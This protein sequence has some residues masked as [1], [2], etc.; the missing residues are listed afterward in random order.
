MNYE[1]F[2]LGPIETN[3]YLLFSPDRQAAIVDPVEI[4]A[5]MAESIGRQRLEVKFILVTH[6]HVDHVHA[7]GELSDRFK[8]PIIMHSGAEKMRPFYRESCAMLGFPVNDLPSDY[9]AADKTG[10]VS[11]GDETLSILTTPG[12][13]PCGISFAA[14]SLVVTGDLLF[15][16]TIGRYDLPFASLA[17]LY[18]S[19]KKIKALP[20]GLAVLPG[21]GPVSTLKS[22]LR[23]N[24]YLRKIP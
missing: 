10:S 11:L 21:H 24:E 16:G 23:F 3:S 12:H 1:R 5:E 6:S 14:G 4:S 9:I 8:A 17:V 18:N 7:A 19:L 20:P 2:V 13:S 22:E 15:K